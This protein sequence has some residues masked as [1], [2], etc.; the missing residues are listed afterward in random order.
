LKINLENGCA[1]KAEEGKVK[2]Y[3]VRVFNGTVHIAFDQG[4]FKEIE[5]TET[6]DLNPIIG[7]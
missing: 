3:P 1:L 7:M 2:V 5:K 6:K 4:G